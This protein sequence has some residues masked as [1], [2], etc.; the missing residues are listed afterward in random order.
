[1]QDQETSLGVNDG[2]VFRCAQ[3]VQYEHTPPLDILSAAKDLSRLS[4]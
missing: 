1:M 3:D 2:E 4:P